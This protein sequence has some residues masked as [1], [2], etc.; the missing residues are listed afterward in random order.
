[1]SLQ[2]T[3]LKAGE[4]LL[5]PSRMSAI[6]INRSVNACRNRPHPWSTRNDYISWPGLTD[7]TYNARLL[8]P[9]PNL[10]ANKG[11][12]PD[13]ADVVALFAVPAGATQRQCIKSSCLFPTFAQYL[14]DGFIRTMVTPGPPFGTGF[15]DRK[16]TTSNHD[17][18]LS[19]LY[20]RTEA[21]TL[22]LR[23]GEGGRLKSETG[24]DG[25]FPPLLFDAAGKVKDEFRI[26]DLPLGLGG[27]TPLAT[28]FAVGGDRANAT[29]SVS[30]MNALFLRE[31]NRLARLF[32]KRHPDWDDERLFQTARNVVIVIYIKLVVEEY[33][34]H[35]STASVRFLAESK[36]AWAAKWNRTNWMTAEFSLLYRWHSLIPGKIM[37]GNDNANVTLDNSL[38]LKHGVARALEQTAGNQA[39]NLGLQNTIAP[40]LPFEER[41]IKQGR[42]NNL[43]GYNAYRQAAG[44]KPARSFA[45]VVGTS[46]DAGERARLSAL[47]AR[48]QQLYGSVDNLEFYVGLFAERTNRNGPLP[49]LIQTMVAVDAFSQA[50]TNPLLS[51]HIWG[52][53]KTRLLAFTKEGLEAITETRTVG[54]IVAR[55][56]S[57]KV[58]PMS[59]TL[60]AWKRS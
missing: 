12:G 37:W 55:N 48:L 58:G 42:T 1:M 34:N 35:I 40:L 33:I 26:L 27:T 47:A 10:P 9:D 29:P 41:A 59:M 24:V 6:M 28:L 43:A 53:E 52:D 14:T 45:E 51:E 39:S 46:D 20:G 4:F 7:R 60:P 23:S 8:P 13:V 3:L 54:D 32:E 15:E 21:Q 25:E 11:A 2:D 56:S 49:P 38:L 30:A 18:D 44:M 16:R 36:V 22:A 50:L 17:I 57:D 31:H 19:P 5:G